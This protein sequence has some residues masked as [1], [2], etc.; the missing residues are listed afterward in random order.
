MIFNF[1]HFSIEQS[2]AVL[3]VGTDAFVLGAF[4][5]ASSPKNILDIGA[6]TGVLSLIAAQKFQNANIDAIEIDAESAR[7]AAKN[8]GNS[9]WTDRLYIHHSSLQ[10][11]TTSKTYDLIVSNPPFFENSSAADTEVKNRVKHNGGLSAS[12]L[13]EKV[14]R[15]LSEEGE[16]WLILSVDFMRNYLKEIERFKLN[17]VQEISVFGKPEFLKRKILVLS[18]KPSHKQKIDF[19][20]R[21][22]EGKYSDEYIALTK[23][24]HD[25]AL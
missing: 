7:L 6:G 8:F 11:F 10:D 24:L 16:C 4:F 18:K 13:I 23:E 22:K 3:K 14:D 12:E 9:P 2:N 5:E 25:R 1:K 15:F 20:I 21:N 17:I 19:T